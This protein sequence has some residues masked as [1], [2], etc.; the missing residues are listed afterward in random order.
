MPFTTWLHIGLGPDCS[1]WSFRGGLAPGKILCPGGKEGLGCCSFKKGG[2][3][4]VSWAR[5]WAVC[6]SHSTSALGPEL[7]EQR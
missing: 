4:V 1:A 5:A 3:E 7:L 6:Q 2:W